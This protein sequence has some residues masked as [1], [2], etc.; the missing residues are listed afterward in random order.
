MPSSQPAD[1]TRLAAT[2]V[3]ELPRDPRVQV[4]NTFPAL[5]AHGSAKCWLRANYKR[6]CC[7]LASFPIH[8][9]GRGGVLKGHCSFPSAPKS[10]TS[11]RQYLIHLGSRHLQLTRQLARHKSQGCWCCPTAVTSQI[12]TEPLA[13]RSTHDLPEVLPLPLLSVQELCSSSLRTPLSKEPD[14]GLF[15]RAELQPRVQPQRTVFLLEFSWCM[16]ALFWDDHYHDQR[17]FLRIEGAAVTERLPDSILGRATGFSHVGIVPDDATGRQVFSGIYPFPPHHH[18]DAAPHSPQSPSSALKTSLLR[19]SHISSL[20]HSVYIEI[21]TLGPSGPASCLVARLGAN[22]VAQT[23]RQVDFKSAHLFV[24]SLYTGKV[25]AGQPLLWELLSS[26]RTTCSKGRN[27]TDVSTDL[28]THSRKAKRGCALQSP[29]IAVRGHRLALIYLFHDVHTSNVTFRRKEALRGALPRLRY[30]YL[31]NGTWVVIPRCPTVYRR[32]RR[33]V[34]LQAGGRDIFAVQRRVTGL[35]RMA[36]ST[37]L[38]QLRISWKDNTRGVPGDLT[39]AFRAPAATAP[40]QLLS[41]V[42]GRRPTAVNFV[43]SR[44]KGRKSLSAW[45]LSLRAGDCQC[46]ALGATPSFT[47]SSQLDETPVL[48]LITLRKPTCSSQTTRL[49]TRFSRTETKKKKK[50]RRIFSYTVVPRLCNG[51][52]ARALSLPRSPHRTLQLGDGTGANGIE[53]KLSYVDII[54]NTYALCMGGGRGGKADV[55]GPVYLYLFATSEAEKRISS[56]TSSP[57]RVGIGTDVQCPPRAA[58]TYGTLSGDPIDLLAEMRTN[59]VRCPFG[60]ISQTRGTAVSERLDFSPSVKA[61]RIVPGRATPG[62]SHVGIVLDDA[63]GRQVFSRISCF[64]PPLYSDVAPFSPHF[65]LVG[66]QDVVVKSPPPPTSLII[67]WK[68]NFRRA[69]EKLK[70]TVDWV[71]SSS[72]VVFTVEIVN[73]PRSAE[74]VA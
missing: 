45:S 7:Y 72:H 68:Q 44:S 43:S 47:S 35:H 14:Q 9:C 57:Q 41:L 17:K 63:T 67:A 49:S 22:L 5:R 33:K 70:V 69:A 52:S 48:R 66:S 20:I 46:D 25:E 6:S 60:E 32:H 53:K 56:V 11:S 24:N 16:C 55:K 36:G 64:P 39:A 74:L 71:Y 23:T 62:F 54:L 21:L 13:L 28:E 51:W 3:S 37:D 26:S 15:Q 40:R 29:A 58:C 4:S 8:D 73:R 10:G 31:R 59:A 30:A 2:G 1:V 34:R 19:N 12:V 65:A 42:T 50:K 27:V 18:S 61:N 38:V